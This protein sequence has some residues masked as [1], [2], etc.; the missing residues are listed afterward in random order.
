MYNLKNVVYECMILSK[1]MSS[2][3]N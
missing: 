2:L 1:C 3:K